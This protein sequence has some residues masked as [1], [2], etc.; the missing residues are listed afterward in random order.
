MLLLDRLS[1]QNGVDMTISTTVS[2]SAEPAVKAFHWTT[3]PVGAWNKS[4]F[5]ITGYRGFGSSL[6]NMKAVPLARVVSYPVSAALFCW[7]WLKPDGPVAPGSHPEIEEAGGFDGRF[8]EFWEELKFQ[9]PH[10]LLAERSQAMLSWHFRYSNSHGK[11]WVLTASEGSRL[12]AYAIF[13]RQDNIAYGLKR[14]RL[15]DFQALKGSENALLSALCR[16]LHRC[17]DEGIHIVENIGCW[18]ERPGL[19]RVP[20]AYHRNLPSAMFYYNSTDKAFSETLRDPRVWA[21][22]SLDGDASL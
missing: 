8:D 1:R 10:V 4:A 18:L 17:R 13:D 14:V 6:L 5:W 21:P 15:V 3:P 19:P 12:T 2:P 9:N 11:V 20:T 7:D 22:T 16:M